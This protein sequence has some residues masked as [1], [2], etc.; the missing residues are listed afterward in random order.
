MKKWFSVLVLVTLLSSIPACTSGKKVEFVQG[1]NRI[2]VIINNIPVT[3]Y[4]YKPGLAKPILYPVRTPSGITLNRGYPFEEVEGESHDH[5]HHTGV[6][7]TYD[8]SK[9]ER[10]WASTT[11]PPQI[12]HVKVTEKS[13]GKEKGTLSTV[14]HWVGKSG[15]TLL[16]EKRT[17]VFY[18]GE[19]EYA[20][21]FI[22]TLT[23]VNNTV[24]FEATKE[25]MF[26][27]RVAHWLKEKD[28]AGKYLSSRGGL[29]A[30]DIWGR[31]AEWVSL[32]GKKDES[33]AGIAILNHPSSTNFPTYWHARNYGLFS[34]NPLGQSVF[35]KSTGVENPEPFELTLQPGESAIFRF[36]MIIYDG[37]RSKAVIE[38]KFEEYRKNI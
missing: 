34:A 19:N 17:M 27:V 10:F 5:P 3:A 15:K 6:F 12:R 36:M 21:D 29:S 14:L 24:V 30:N 22:I 35:Q 1:E 11:P 26:A 20:I 37:P 18:P 38:Q 16:E 13:G 8:I 31:R 28:G 23:A 25:G 33:I 32:E 9:E 4:L 7:F 2:D